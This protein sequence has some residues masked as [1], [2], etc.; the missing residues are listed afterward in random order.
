MFSS[1]GNWHCCR[2]LSSSA[3]DSPRSSRAALK[4]TMLDDHACS[5]QDDNACSDVPFTIT[6]RDARFRGAFTSTP[7]CGRFKS[8]VKVVRHNDTDFSVENF[9]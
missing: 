3:R 2:D 5:A 8:S 9:R 4:M 6:L 1:I 7:N